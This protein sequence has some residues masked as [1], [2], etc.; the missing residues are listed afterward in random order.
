MVI[1]IHIDWFEKICK[2]NIEEVSKHA[3]IG[4]TTDNMTACM[5]CLKMKWA[6]KD[7]H[8]TSCNAWFH[9][10]CGSQK[11]K[12]TFKCPLCGLV[13]S[14]KKTRGRKPQKQSKK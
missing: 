6:E 3:T 13:D 10:D 8:C 2:T 14:I 11:N 9:F 12:T 7:A 1:N 5:K 4:D